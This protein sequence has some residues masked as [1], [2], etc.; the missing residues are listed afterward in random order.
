M[1]HKPKNVTL[2]IYLFSAAAESDVEGDDGLC[3]LVHVGGLAELGTEEVLLGGEHFEVTGL[4]IIHQFVGA[5]VGLMEYLHLTVVV[6][7]LLAG[8]LTVG[9]RLVHLI[10]SVDDGLDVLLLQVFLSELVNLVVG[11]DLAFGK[12]G[13]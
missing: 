1:K 9:H 4:A 2:L 8:S 3:T 11:L 13:L 7:V 10:A 5:D 6:V 12:D